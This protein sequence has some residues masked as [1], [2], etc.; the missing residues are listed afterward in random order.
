MY[1][2]SYKV[3]SYF[4][5]DILKKETGLNMLTLE[6]EYDAMEAGPMKMRIETFMQT[7]RR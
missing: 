2:E 6:S 5:P 3:E 1:R 4:F 7:V